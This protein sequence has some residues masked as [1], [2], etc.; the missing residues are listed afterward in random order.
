M[1]AKL[2]KYLS[3]IV[4]VGFFTLLFIL[5]FKTTPAYSEAADHVVISEIQV[6]G[7]V[8]TDEFVELYNPNDTAEDLTGWKLI[9]KTGSAEAEETL[10]V[11]L[12]GS[13]PAHGFYLIAHTD[14][15]DSPTEDDTYTEDNYSGNN[16]V[17][18]RDDSN[19]LVD[20]VGMGTSETSEG[21]N[22]VQAPINNRSIERK[23]QAD[24]TAEDMAPG[25]A[26]ENMGNSE[27]SGNNANDFVR[28]GS[29]TVSVPQNSGSATEM[30]DE[31]STPTPTATPTDE[32]TDNPSPTATP[33]EEPT[34]T[35]TPTPTEEPTASPSP[36][37]T[38]TPNGDKI[39]GFF[40][41][42]GNFKV[43]YIH[44]EV[45][46][47]GFMYFSFPTLYCEAL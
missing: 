10:L 41:F 35:P 39:I 9:K 16:T 47:F 38:V 34:M 3:L 40:P 18:L 1:T 5:M 14:Y 44:Y 13:I 42:P 46:Q 36:S 2:P 25:G 22:P 21:D 19:G 12:D 43:C 45:R 28:H 4:I 27:D 33:T 6:A 30:L 31:E 23:A 20:M 11:T 26:H 7:D 32:P 8:S 29:P 24:S 17:I 15:D 37:P